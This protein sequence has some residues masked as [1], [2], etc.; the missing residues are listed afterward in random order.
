MMGH[1]NPQTPEPCGNNHVPERTRNK[2]KSNPRQ[3][4]NKSYA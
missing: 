1:E 3:L 2:T 4:N